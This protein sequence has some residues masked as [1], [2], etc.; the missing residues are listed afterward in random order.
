MCE[1]ILDPSKVKMHRDVDKHLG[2]GQYSLKFL[3]KQKLIPPPTQID[4][5]ICMCFINLV[6]QSIEIL[7]TKSFKHFTITW[8]HK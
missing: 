5:L 7:S 2:H 4:L 3:I 6:I 8:Q 1:N